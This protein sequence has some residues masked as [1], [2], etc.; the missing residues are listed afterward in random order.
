MLKKKPATYK[1][2]GL[3]KAPSP[4][5][6]FLSHVAAKGTVKPPTRRLNAKTFV[7]GL[8]AS[9][10]RWYRAQLLTPLRGLF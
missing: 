7:K 1:A 9:R 10:Q 5:S 6:V 4:W 3:R 2:L 8:E